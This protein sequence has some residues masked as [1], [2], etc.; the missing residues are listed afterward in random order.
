MEECA[1][2]ITII[3][4]VRTD[5]MNK[6]LISILLAVIMI[7]GTTAVGL[8]AFAEGDEWNCAEQG[9]VAMEYAVQGVEVQELRGGR[10]GD[11][12]DAAGRLQTAVRARLI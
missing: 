5:I 2:V 12:A 3:Q 7:F 4:K 6:K 1:A 10:A 9:H 8:T 11:A